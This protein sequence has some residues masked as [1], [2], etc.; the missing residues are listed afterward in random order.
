MSVTIDMETFRWVS[1]A[2]GYILGF[3]TP[4]AFF[5]LIALSNMFDR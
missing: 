5:A 1:F 3:L 4:I 2:G